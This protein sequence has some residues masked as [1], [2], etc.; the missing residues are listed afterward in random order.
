MI[1]CQD[2][3]GVHPAAT[4]GVRCACCAGDTTSVEP[5]PSCAEVPADRA[6]GFAVTVWVAGVASQEAADRV[7]GGM[8]GR[9]RAPEGVSATVVP[10]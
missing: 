4:P 10:D 5:C 1:R 3:G 2:C 8:L 6:P 9:A 7:V